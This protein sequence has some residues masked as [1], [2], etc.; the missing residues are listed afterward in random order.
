MKWNNAKERAKFEREQ[1]QK[2]KEY[3][4]AGMTEEQIEILRT[5][6][7]DWYRSRRREALHT[8]RLE[9]TAFDEENVDDES[10]SP[11]L[12][13]FLHNFSVVDEHFEDDRLGWI[14]QIDNEKLYLAVKSLSSAD[15]EL[16]TKL[17]F[18]GFTQT[19]IARVEGV[20][21]VVICKKIKRIKN[22]LKK[23][24]ENG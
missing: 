21:K 8:Q 19:E 3:L 5:Y 20:A 18:D 22:F 14:E 16:L 12:K 15:K 11:L 17:L 23:V 2:L 6:D 4:A 7:E 1:A 24:L 10:K 9:I 13:K